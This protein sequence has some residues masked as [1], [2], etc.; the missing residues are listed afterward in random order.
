MIS[1][2]FSAIVWIEKGIVFVIADEKNLYIRFT[3]NFF[4]K[5]EIIT[6]SWRWLE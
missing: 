2:R 1:D 6:L 3:A 5:Q 4:I